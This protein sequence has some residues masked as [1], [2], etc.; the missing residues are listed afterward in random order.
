MCAFPLNPD[1]DAD[2]GATVY[3]LRAGRQPVALIRLTIYAPLVAAGNPFALLRQSVGTALG[4]AWSGAASQGARAERGE[5]GG[6]GNADGQARAFCFSYFSRKV[7]VL[8]RAAALCRTQNCKRRAGS[9]RAFIYFCTKFSFAQLRRRAG[10]A[11]PWGGEEV[12]GRGRTR[13]FLRPSSLSHETFLK[14]V[15]LAWTHL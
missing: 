10:I 5:R 7:R 1:G 4:R 3:Q 6:T 2:A 11:S 15:Q 14:H 13:P 9:A 12:G 8:A